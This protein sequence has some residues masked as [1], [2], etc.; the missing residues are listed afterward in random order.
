MVVDAID[1]SGKAELVP[2]NEM[3][4]R[5]QALRACAATARTITHKS[6]QL[7]NQQLRARAIIANA[8]MTQAQ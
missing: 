1:A 7:P 3:P 5:G 6:V 4:K 2:R 8:A